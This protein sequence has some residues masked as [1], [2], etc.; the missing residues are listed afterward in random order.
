[1]ATPVAASKP[2]LLTCKVNTTTSPTFA[3]WLLTDFIN[4]KSDV[5]TIT[6]KL[7]SSSSAIPSPKSS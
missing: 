5:S 6:S 3:F 2:K 1:M 4:S 7:A